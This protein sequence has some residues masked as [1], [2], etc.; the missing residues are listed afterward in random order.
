MSRVIGL[1]LLLCLSAAP[2]W[3]KG[4]AIYFIDVEGGQ[5]TLIVTPDGQSLLIDAGFGRGS[6]DPDRILAAARDAGLERID[7]MM[8]THFH[9][10]HVG[11]I[12]ELASRIP[13]ITYVD[14]GG[15]MGTIYGNDRMT[16][17]SF[18]QYEQARNLG[19]HHVPRPG[20]RLPLTGVDA[21]FVSSGGALI[22]S[23]LPGGGEAND[24][25]ANLEDHP[26][27]G[28][29]NFRSLGI[30]LK[31]GAFTFVD[32]GDLSGK[33]LQKLV[34]PMN[35]LGAASVYL[36]SHH[37]DYDSDGPAMYRALKPRVAVMNNGVTKGGDPQTFRTVHAQSGL[38]LW[39]LHASQRPDAQNAPDDF[40]ANL[41]DKDGDGN[42]I[43]LNA[44][45]DGSFIVTNG[46]TGFTRSYTAPVKGPLPAMN[47]SSRE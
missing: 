9:G 31:F 4:L 32:V 5:S 38:D 13:I 8:V 20:G 26:E 15:P 45:T 6:R 16:V 19:G 41:D 21:T 39:Q 18:A 25:C 23:P 3:A 43:K 17:R 47:T 35:M 28:T 14:Y 7:Y 33:T 2:A 34:C 30:V 12:P 10:D 36:I 29:E 37:G 40:I 1:V 42:W 27:D 46:R 24:G 22:T 44:N 11:G